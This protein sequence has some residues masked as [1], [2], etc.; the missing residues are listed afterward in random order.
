MIPHN[1]NVQWNDVEVTRS[2][3][4][5]WTSEVS[6][7]EDRALSIPGTNVQIRTTSENTMKLVMTFSGVKMR[8]IDS[9][10]WVAE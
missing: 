8:A 4:H 1:M 9:E 3:L 10:I 6:Y 5:P 2:W 7:T